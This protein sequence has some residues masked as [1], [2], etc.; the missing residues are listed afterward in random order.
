MGGLETRDEALERSRI[1]AKMDTKRPQ[2]HL[3][4][5]E[6]GQKKGLST[7]R[8]S[9][10]A[11]TTPSAKLNMA[12]MRYDEA[13]VKA[14]ALMAAGEARGSMAPSSGLAIVRAQTDAD[15]VVRALVRYNAMLQDEYYTSILTSI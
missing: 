9:T 15:L 5:V 3:G 1:E 7:A 11:Q 6:D 10:N 2:S 12:N 8:D 13:M 4:S 14:L